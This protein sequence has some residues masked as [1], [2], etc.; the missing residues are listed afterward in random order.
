MVSRDVLEEV[1]SRLKEVSRFQGVISDTTS[2]T[3]SK[4]DWG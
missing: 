1:C 4:Q 2:K 3:Q